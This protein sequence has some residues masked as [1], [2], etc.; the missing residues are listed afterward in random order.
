MCRFKKGTWVPNNTR[1]QGNQQHQHKSQESA[2]NFFPVANT[3]N[4]FQFSY[5][6]NL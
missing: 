3:T 1:T 5:G 6:P 4:S 2:C